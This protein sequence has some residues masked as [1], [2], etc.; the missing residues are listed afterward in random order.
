MMAATPPPAAAQEAV[1][2]ELR[3]IEHELSR[4]MRALKGADEAPVLRAR[5]SN[6]VIVCDRPDLADQVAAQI[7]DI[8]AVH[9]ARVLL[10]VGEPEGKGAPERDD[11][12]SSFSGPQH[13]PITAT[14]HVYSHRL[15]NHQQAC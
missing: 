12:N 13:S 4:Q 1:A 7:P 8:V 5:M 9:P 3:D 6:L 10:L 2:V 11:G 15:N 14:V